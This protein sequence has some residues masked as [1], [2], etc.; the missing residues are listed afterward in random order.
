[1]KSLSLRTQRALRKTKTVLP[2]VFLCILGALRVLSEKIFS[3]FGV[4]RAE[5]VAVAGRLKYDGGA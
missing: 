4:G 1:M 5:E 3:S 2:D